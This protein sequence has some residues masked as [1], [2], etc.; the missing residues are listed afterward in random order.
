MTREILL[1][2]DDAY[3]APGLTVIA[4]FLRRYGNVLTVAPR[5]P[6]SA[7]SMALTMEEPLYLTKY[8]YFEP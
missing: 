4:Q 7:R 2:N 3:T 5:F 6:Q 8:A 1:T